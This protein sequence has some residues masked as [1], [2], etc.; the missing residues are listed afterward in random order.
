MIDGKACRIFGSDAP[1]CLLIQLAERNELPRLAAEAGQIASLREV[2]FVLVAIEVEN[3]L[4]DLMPWP[5][6]N[7]SRDPEAG[8]HGH[9]MLD[10]ILLSLVPELEK[11]YGTLPVILGG[12]SLGG[13]FAL[14]ASSQSDRF[15]AI[16]AASPSPSVWIKDWIPYAQKH[17]PLADSVYLSLGDREEFVK[18]QAIARVGDNLRTQYAQ[19]QEQLGAQHCTLVW[20]QGNHFSDSEGRLARAFAWCL[21]RAGAIATSPH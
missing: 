19:L 7:V 1:V 12:Y 14:W 21:D 9:E 6:G 4:V 2:P 8:K 10:Y 11:R 18:N 3:W 13:L 16:A 15:N 17:I 5:D 20:E